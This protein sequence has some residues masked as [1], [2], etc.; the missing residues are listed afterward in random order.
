MKVLLVDDEPDISEV[1]TISFNLRW[2]DARVLSVNT[3]GKSIELARRETPDI[4]VLDVEL[5]DMDGFEVCHQLREFVEGPIVILTA[6]DSEIDKVKGLE[7]G[8]DDGT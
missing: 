7:L 3:G 5:P 6:R 8:A 1:I 4:V 2:P